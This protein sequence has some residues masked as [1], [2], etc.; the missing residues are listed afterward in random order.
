M[1]TIDL[2]GDEESDCLVEEVTSGEGGSGEG[3]SGEGVSGEG[4][5]GEGGSGEGGSREGV[6]GE[7]GLGEGA[8]VVDTTS[9]E[10]EKGGRKMGHSNDEDGR[11]ERRPVSS[12]RGRKKGALTALS[13]NDI[14]V[15]T[16][17]S[18]TSTPTSASTPISASIPTSSTSTPT[19]PAL[20]IVAVSDTHGMES[21]L[22]CNFLAL[23]PNLP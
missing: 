6:S 9:L 11:K 23:S 18:S 5:S 12:L 14:P 1:Y 21:V 17:T 3:G 15:A 22:R 13:A 16:P 19:S 7:G 8:S 10:D 4:V 2:L 20:R